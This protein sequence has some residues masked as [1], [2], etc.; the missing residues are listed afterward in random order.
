MSVLH[1][2]TLD[3]RGNYHL[4][5]ISSDC[6]VPGSQINCEKVRKDASDGMMDKLASMTD[7]RQR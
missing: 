6:P 2:E 1:T 5:R 7:G 3:Y 4:Y